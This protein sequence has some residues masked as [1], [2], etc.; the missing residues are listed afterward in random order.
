MCGFTHSVAGGNG[1][2]N[3]GSLQSPNFIAGST[4]WQLTKDGNW[5]A[6]A[7]TYRGT[8]TVGKPGQQQLVITDRGGEGQ[9]NFIP[10]NPAFQFAQ[11]AQADVGAYESLALLGPNAT[12]AGHTDYAGIGLNSSDGTSTAN[13]VLTYTAPDGTDTAAAS[14][15]NDSLTVYVPF[16]ATSGTAQAPTV[17]TTDDWHPMALSGAWKASATGY[18]QYKLMPDATVM[19]RFAGLTPGTVAD[20]TVIWTAPPGY[21]TT[22]GATMSFFLGVTYETAPAAVTS[23]PEVIVRGASLEVYNLRGTVASIATVIRYPLD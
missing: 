5:E 7:G 10:N 9:I 3:T 8:V 13:G 4:G 22:F 2:L 18:A 16:T 1:N 19:V 20:G 14:W 6:N 15:N 23:T 21:A 11:I 12:A 17:I